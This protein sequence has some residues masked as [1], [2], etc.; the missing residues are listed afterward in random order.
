MKKSNPKV[1]IEILIIPTKQTNDVIYISIPE[2]DVV[3]VLA[4][5]KKLTF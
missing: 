1:V 2:Y 4:V 5:E 3:R